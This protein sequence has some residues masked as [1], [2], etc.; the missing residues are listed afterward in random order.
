MRNLIQWFTGPIDGIVERHQA[1]S[2]VIFL[3]AI[4]ILGLLLWP[5]A[6]KAGSD[7]PFLS[8]ALGVVLLLFLF[9]KTK[10]SL[11]VGNLVTLLIYGA[12]VNLSF[13]SGGIYS[14]DIAGIILVPLIAINLVGWQGGLF[15]T[16]TS[17]F[18]SIYHYIKGQNSE[19]LNSYKNQFLGFEL[20]YFLSFNLVILLIPMS[21]VFLFVKL[22]GTLISEIKNRNSEL[23]QAN[24]ILANQTIQLTQTKNKLQNSNAL[25]KKY[26]HITSHDL[27]QPIRTIA[28]F[29][30]LLNRELDK[31]N[32]SKENLQGYLKQISDGSIRMNTQVEEILS[33]SKTNEKGLI[34][35]TD[36]KS[37]IDQV[38]ADLGSQIGD[39]NL[40]LKTSELPII[41]GVPSTIYKLF[42]NLISNAI[43]YKHPERDLTLSIN[44][45]EENEIWTFSVEDNGI[46]IPEDKIDVIFDYGTQLDPKKEGAGIGLNTIK[47][48][49]N[50]IGGEIW[51]NSQMGVG[52][53]FNF[54][55]PKL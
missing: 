8:S 9:K 37:I 18:P 25:L 42:Q 16:I 34:V 5:I 35:K 13:S 48:F 21:L 3:I 12:I 15:W 22:N 10:S 54:T 50:K 1:R 11:L 49:I 41:D 32:P 53:T 20:E 19:T 17:I 36:I 46:G 24:E 26:A 27:K 51:V 39:C 44:A 31:E 29:T 33:F 7:F 55:Y 4:I 52:S 28:S 14:M 23:D 2:I 30:Q 40:K 47:E 38:M 43:K 45:K 6:S